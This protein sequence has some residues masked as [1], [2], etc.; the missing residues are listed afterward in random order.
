MLDR[1]DKTQAQ[2]AFAINDSQAQMNYLPPVFAP[3][4]G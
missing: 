4:R 1:T 3:Y 2:V